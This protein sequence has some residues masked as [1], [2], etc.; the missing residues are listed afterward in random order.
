MSVIA[1]AGLQAILPD[2]LRTRFVEAALSYIGCHSEGEFV[3]RDNDCWCRC[4]PEFPQCNCPEADLKA[5]EDS[6]RQIRESWKQANQEFEE[7][8]EETL[9]CN[10][11]HMIF[12]LYFYCILMYAT[13]VYGKPA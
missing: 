1:A 8:G 2:Y 10:M 9:T 5:M 3:C 13:L 6:L 11:S 7:S 12:L 4:A